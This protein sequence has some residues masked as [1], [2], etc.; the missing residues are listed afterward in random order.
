MGTAEEM[1]PRVWAELLWAIDQEKLFSDLSSAMTSK[2]GH[3]LDV[4][5]GGVDVFVVSTA[6]MLSQYRGS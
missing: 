3:I 1:L 5:P 6:A 2:S 4:I